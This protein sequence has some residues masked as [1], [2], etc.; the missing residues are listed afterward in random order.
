MRIPNELNSEFLPPHVN[1]AYE[2]KV[3]DKVK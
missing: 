3:L 1:R 2:S